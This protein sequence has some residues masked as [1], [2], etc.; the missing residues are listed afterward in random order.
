MNMG[1]SLLQ[2]LFLTYLRVLRRTIRMEWAEDEI[3]PG[4]QIFGFWHEDSFCMNL[5]LEQVDGRT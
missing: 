2:S 4:R 3:G 1:R 5:V